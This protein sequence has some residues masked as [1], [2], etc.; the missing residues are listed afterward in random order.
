MVIY[1]SDSILTYVFWHD[2]M[3]RHTITSMLDPTARKIAS[4]GDNATTCPR[5]MFNSTI[6]SL[7]RN[8]DSTKSQ[9]VTDTYALKSR[10]VLYIYN[11][12]SSIG[13]TPRREVRPTENGVQ[14]RH[15]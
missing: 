8:I 10:S 15:L 4:P 1:I 6:M 12:T 2:G 14:G 11:N 5:Q 7:K 13:R 3:I 9:V